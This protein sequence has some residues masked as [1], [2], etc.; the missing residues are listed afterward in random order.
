[1][2]G[3]LGLDAT[4]KWESEGYPREWPAV[5]EMSDDVRARVSE[6]WAELGIEPRR[7]ATAPGDGDPCCRGGADSRGRRRGRG[8][9]TAARARARGRRGAGHGGRALGHAAVRHARRR[10]PGRVAR[11][12]R[13][14]GARAARRRRR[15]RPGRAAGA[16]A[17]RRS[18]PPRPAAARAASSASPACPGR[19]SRPTRR[20]RSRSWRAHPCSA[21]GSAPFEAARRLIERMPVLPCPRWLRDADARPSPRPTSCGR[22]SSSPASRPPRDGRSSW[23]GPSA[24]ARATCS[25]PSPSC[26][27]AARASS[28]C[29]A[30]CRAPPRWRWERPAGWAAAGRRACVERLRTGTEPRP[31]GL[32]G[33]AHEPATPPRSALRGALAA[34]RPRG[35]RMTAAGRADPLFWYHLRA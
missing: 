33:L 34:G 28:T 1:M 4:A 32:D 3:K 11:G 9:R 2:G 14:P 15:R 8:G 30:S 5:A 10:A 21:P 20:C 7:P 31:G 19:R 18:M 23:A 24:R 35:G 17:P 12:S 27:A 13:G 26:S 16:P 29:R 25:P 22:W 6:R